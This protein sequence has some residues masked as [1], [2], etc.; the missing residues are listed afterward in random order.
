VLEDGRGGSSACWRPL[1]REDAFRRWRSSPRRR[2]GGPSAAA[3]SRGRA[4]SAGA[5]R[6]QGSAASSLLTWTRLCSIGAWAASLTVRRPA[7]FGV[8]IASSASMS[9]R[10]C[11]RPRGG[12]APRR[13]R[14]GERNRR[15]GSAAG[16]GGAPAPVQAPCF[17]KSD[18][19]PTLGH[20]CSFAQP[21]LDPRRSVTV[22]APH[23]DVLQPAGAI[24]AYTHGS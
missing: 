1:G 24:S 8:G 19:V 16:R 7:A 22:V 10:S 4:R 2:G 6:C 13:C 20:Q 12:S 11:P 9:L 17:S 5:G 18:P 14:A 21:G 3:S 15:S 23:A